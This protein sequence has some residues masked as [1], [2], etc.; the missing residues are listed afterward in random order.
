M[1]PSSTSQDRQR[2][3]LAFAES[4]ANIP[5]GIVVRSTFSHRIGNIVDGETTVGSV[6]QYTANGAVAFWMSSKFEK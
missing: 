4:I 3:R 2:D 6:C 5:H 1:H